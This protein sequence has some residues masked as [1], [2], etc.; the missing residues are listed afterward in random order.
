MSFHEVGSGHDT[1]ICLRVVCVVLLTVE[2]WDGR[3]VGVWRIGRHRSRIRTV[4]RERGTGPIRGGPGK[5]G[6]SGVLDR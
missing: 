2:K 1:S 6:H 4:V 5:L 3:A